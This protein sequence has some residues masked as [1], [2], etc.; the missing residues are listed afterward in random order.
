MVG[1]RQRDV[2][3]KI[4]IQNYMPFPDFWELRLNS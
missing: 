4:G 2:I 3:Q 1:D